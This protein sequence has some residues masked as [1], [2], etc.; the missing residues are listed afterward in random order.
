MWLRITYNKLDAGSL[1]ELGTTCHKMLFSKIVNF[2][3]SSL[4]FSTQAPRFLPDPTNLL[5]E[6]SNSSCFLVSQD[7]SSEPWGHGA[8]FCHRNNAVPYASTSKCHPQH[9]SCISDRAGRQHSGD[10]VSLGGKQAP[11]DLTVASIIGGLL[12]SPLPLSPRPQRTEP[13]E[14]SFHA[15]ELRC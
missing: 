3:V 8:W 13:D 4:D 6:D 9:N 2:S 11:P 7:S 15:L 1:C 14:S 5:E 10:H 12:V